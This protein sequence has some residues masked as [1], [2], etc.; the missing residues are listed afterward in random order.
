MVMIT[1]DAD[2]V[3]FPYVDEDYVREVFLPRES[4]YTDTPITHLHL[5]EYRR[6]EFGPRMDVTLADGRRKW[7]TFPGGFRHSAFYQE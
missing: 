1:V 4:K 5:R 6:Y 2:K 7:V 3:D